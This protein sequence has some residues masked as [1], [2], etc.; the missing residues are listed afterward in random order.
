MTAWMIRKGRVD[1]LWKW[2]IIKCFGPRDA[3]YKHQRYDISV[4]LGK[5]SRLHE[6][7]HGQIRGPRSKAHSKAPSRRKAKQSR[8]EEHLQ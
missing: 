8:Y 3:P 1:R 4:L 7:L 5:V 6:T 2:T